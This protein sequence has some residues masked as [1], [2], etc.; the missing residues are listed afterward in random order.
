MPRLRACATKS[1][2]PAARRG[3]S[4]CR[5][6]QVGGEREAGDLP[7]PLQ[8]ADQVLRAVELD[9][10]V[11]ASALDPHVEQIRDRRA[12]PAVPRVEVVVRKRARR[13]ERLG[14]KNAL[15]EGSRSLRGGES[16]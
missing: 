11:I 4:L 15:D 13:A 16:E 14:S 10:A 2:R 6:S 7:E 1:V 3:G 12:A 8:R 5:S 9:R